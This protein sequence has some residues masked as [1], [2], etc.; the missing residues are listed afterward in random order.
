MKVFT[1][2]AGV[3]LSLCCIAEVHANPLKDLVSTRGTS[4]IKYERAVG[5]RAESTQLSADGPA[6]GVAVAVVDDGGTGAGDKVAAAYVDGLRQ[7]LPESGP[8]PAWDGTQPQFGGRLGRGQCGYKM[9]HRTLRRGV[10]CRA[11]D[12]R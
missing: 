9:P 11:P 8:L 3:L 1:V 12:P 5:R 2:L 7:G 4:T 10:P 6:A